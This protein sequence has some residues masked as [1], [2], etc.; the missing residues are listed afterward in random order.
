[1]GFGL[2]AVGML[3]MKLDSSPDRS[4]TGLLPRDALTKR[5]ADEYSELGLTAKTKVSKTELQLG[6]IS[7]FLPIAFASPTRLLPQ[8]FRGLSSLK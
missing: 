3:G 4:G 1:M 7:T 2:D 6:T 5:A 8:T